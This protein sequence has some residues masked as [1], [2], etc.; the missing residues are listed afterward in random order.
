VKDHGFLDVEGEGF[1]NL[2][3]K[4]GIVAFPSASEGGAASV[5]TAVAC[6]AGVPVVTQATGLDIDGCG[7]VLEGDSVEELVLAIN[8]ILQMP[9]SEYCLL[10]ETAQSR[11]LEAFAPHLYRARLSQ[12]FDAMHLT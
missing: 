11:F 9:P 6:G 12:A 3:G 4:C 1:W 5:L 7:V 8:G 10:A 2:V